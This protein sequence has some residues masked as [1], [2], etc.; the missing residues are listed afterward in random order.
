MN[1][2]QRAAMQMALEAL[3]NTSNALLFVSADGYSVSKMAADAYDDAEKAI[4]A[5]REALAKPQGEPQLKRERC[6]ECNGTGEMET[7]IG[8]FPCDS[9]GGSC[10]KYSLT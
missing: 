6:P 9:C 10:V 7:G 3:H 2:R 8:M 4:T 5:L 1:D